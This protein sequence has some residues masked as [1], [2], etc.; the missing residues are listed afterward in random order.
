MFNGCSGLTS[1]RVHFTDWNDAEYSTTSW[2]DGVSATGTFYYKSGSSLD[3]STGINRVP[4]HFTPSA[5][6]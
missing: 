4:E 6:L 3:T 5:T 2:V 1:I